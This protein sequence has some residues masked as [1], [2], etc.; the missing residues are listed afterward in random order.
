MKNLSGKRTIIF[1][2]ARITGLKSLNYMKVKL[3]EVSAQVIDQSRFRKLLWIGTKNA[4]EF[5][6]QINERLE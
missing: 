1:N 4:I 2:T 3:E 5:G 6:K